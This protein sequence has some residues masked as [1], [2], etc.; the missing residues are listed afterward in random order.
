[1]EE[2]ARVKFNDQYVPGPEG[3]PVWMVQKQ[4]THSFTVYVRAENERDALF[5]YLKYYVNHQNEIENPE[6]WDLYVDENTY[7][8]YHASPEH[9]WEKEE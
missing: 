4:W 3:C 2:S 5:E 6:N 7:T 1:M 9:G 8:F